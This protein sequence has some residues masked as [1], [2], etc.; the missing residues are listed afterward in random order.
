MMGNGV[1]KAS[2]VLGFLAWMGPAAPEQPGSAKRTD[3]WK[4]V[5]ATGRVESLAPVA[6]QADWIPVRRGSE[7]APL[8]HIRTFERARTTLT[9][10]GDIILVAAGS[11]VVLPDRMSD[12]ATVVMQKTG[13]AIYKVAPRTGGGRFEVQTPF[14]VAGVKGT[15]FSVILEKDRAAVSVLEGVVEVR[16]SVSGETKDLTAGMVAVV[17]GKLGRVE[18]Y[19]DAGRDRP[20]RG[21]R[22][23][24]DNARPRDREAAKTGNDPSDGTAGGT[25]DTGANAGANVAADLTADVAAVGDDAALKETL[26]ASDKL[27]ANLVEVD[28]SLPLLGSDPGEDLWSDL[29]D[30]RKS[31]ARSTTAVL[32]QTTTQLDP[33]TADPKQDPSLIAKLLDLLNRR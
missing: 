26:R 33:A 27:A 22:E 7:M 10:Q 2:L 12:G 32:D 11:E 8:S 17:D 20:G 29:M 18:T 19:D 5:S 1:L 13:H 28:D 21:R 23:G 25:T 30:E 16:S 3:P 14:L 9:R 15:R 6:G 31:I 4:T 24:R